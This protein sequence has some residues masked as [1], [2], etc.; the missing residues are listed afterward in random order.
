MSLNRQDLIKAVN[1]RLS[2]EETNPAEEAQKSEQQKM[3]EKLTSALTGKNGNGARVVRELLESDATLSNPGNFEKKVDELRLYKNFTATVGAL[4]PQKLFIFGIPLNSVPRR[5]RA[6]E[7]RRLRKLFESARA[8]ILGTANDHQ[9]KRLNDFVALLNSTAQK[10]LNDSVARANDPNAFMEPKPEEVARQKSFNEETV[11]KLTVDEVA[12]ILTVANLTMPEGLNEET[13]D[14][15]RKGTW[16]SADS[17]DNLMEYVAKEFVKTP[18]IALSDKES[19]RSELFNAIDE[20]CTE[21]VN[22]IE[23]ANRVNKVANS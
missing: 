16:L 21:I 11:S 23:N 17:I 15:M 14:R 5:K 10:T 4:S 2:F 8:Q 3:I 1:A 22:H 19:H 18:W 13:I 20:R 9:R 7:C 12:G 6:I